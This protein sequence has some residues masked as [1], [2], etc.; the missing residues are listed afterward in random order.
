MLSPGRADELQPWKG[1]VDKCGPCLLKDVW[2]CCH[3]EDPANLPP[4]FVSQALGGPH[5]SLWLLIVHSWAWGLQGK[6]AKPKP[7]TLGIREA[8]ALAPRPA[9]FSLEWMQT[10]L[11]GSS[12]PP[13]FQS[14]PLPFRGQGAGCW[15]LSPSRECTPLCTMVYVHT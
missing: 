1:L 12:T 9:S 11:K 7:A 13:E 14:G 3:W 2:R 6:L 4:P 15:V 8:K 10:S 5:P